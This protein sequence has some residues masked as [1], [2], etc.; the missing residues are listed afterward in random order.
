METVGFDHAFTFIYSRREGTPAASLPD[1][2]PRGVAQ[3]RF[4]RL[5]L[6][7][8]TLSF[9]ANE[10]EVGAVR[11]CLVEGASKRDATVLA[12]RTPHNRLVHVPLP[13]GT[14]AGQYAGSVRDVHIVSAHPWFLTGEF[15][16][17][18]R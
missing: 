2:V 18:S 3:T 16:A 11:A 13:P 1:T 9:A 10:R 14:D 12:A 17:H 6:L 4:D 8:R 15:T 5:A 7:V